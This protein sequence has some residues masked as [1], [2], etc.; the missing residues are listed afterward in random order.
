MQVSLLQQSDPRS[1]SFSS[2]SSPRLLS[3]ASPHRSCRT[4]QALRS[5]ASDR[6]SRISPQE[7]ARRI[8]GLRGQAEFLKATIK[9]VAVLGV[10]LII[11]KSDQQG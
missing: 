11:L 6:L 9:F 5:T 2:P 4:R 8:F 10:V 3:P 7:G 1:G